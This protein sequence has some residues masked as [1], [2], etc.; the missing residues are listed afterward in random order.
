MLSEEAIREALTSAISK[1]GYDSLHNHSVPIVI[2]NL[3]THYP[4]IEY[5]VSTKSYAIR[6][7]R[8]THIELNEETI[9]GINWSVDETVYIVRDVFSEF[10]WTWSLENNVEAFK[11]IKRFVEDGYTVPL[12]T[13]LVEECEAA[14]RQQRELEAKAKADERQLKLKKRKATEVLK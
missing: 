5:D 14:K 9:R 2:A 4:T 7:D 12:V 11:F 13:Q 10:A 1:M 3:G 6:E 8:I